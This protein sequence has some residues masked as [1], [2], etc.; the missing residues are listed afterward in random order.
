MGTPAGELLTQLRDGQRIDWP[1]VAEWEL[2]DGIRDGLDALPAGETLSSG[3]QSDCPVVIVN[4]KQRLVEVLG[5]SKQLTVPRFAVVKA[6]V[7][8]YPGTCTKDEL[9][10]KSGRDG[11]VNVLKG[12]RSS[13][14]VWEAVIKLAGKAGGGYGLVKPAGH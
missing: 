14:P 12:L 6:L 3:Q 10:T 7:E 2:L 13:D 11:A 1:K 5:Q 8:Q 9:V 4:Q